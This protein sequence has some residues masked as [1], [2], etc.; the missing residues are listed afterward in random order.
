[1]LAQLV[2]AEKEFSMVLSI[3]NQASAQWDDQNLK[4]AG[5]LLAYVDR[6]PEIVE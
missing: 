6:G 3:L 4:A 5:F 2:P 1:V